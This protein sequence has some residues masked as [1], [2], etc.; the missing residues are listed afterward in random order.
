MMKVINKSLHKL[1]QVPTT[2]L[3]SA[4][5]NTFI[6]H[7]F[8]PYFPTSV[9]QDCPNPYTR[10]KSLQGHKNTYYVGALMTF[11]ESAKVWEHAYQLV[12]EKFCNKKITEEIIS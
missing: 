12:N 6:K 5:I 4:S 9:L 11:A 7:E 1:T 8:Q 2:P 3:T 10:I